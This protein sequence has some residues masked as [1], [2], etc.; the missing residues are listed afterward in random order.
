MKIKFSLFFLF[1]LYLFN[2]QISDQ[3]KQLIDPIDKEYFDLTIKEDYDTDKYSKLSE[4]YN[5]IDKT[6]TN[7]ELFYLAVNGS[8]FIRINAIS[9]LIDRNDKR[10]VDLYRY[11]SKFT[12]IYYQ[13]MGCVV[14]AQD[15]ALS[16][17]RGK[18]MNKIKFYELYKH[19]KT[20]K[21]WELLFSNED[22]EYYEKFNVG[23]F[24]LYVKAFDEIDKKFIPERIET[25]DS[26][27]EI[28]KDNKLHVPSL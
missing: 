4:M 13:K 1:S 10:I 27:K 18:I 19:M 14:T 21:N 26:I 8:T 17:I 9:S 15:M 11:Y 16:S 22:I 20:Q 23:D 3:L 12:L 7:D 6:A 5:E 25:N 28:W 2:A 24:K